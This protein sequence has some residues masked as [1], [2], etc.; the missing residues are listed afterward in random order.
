MT[1]DKNLRR[2][3]RRLKARAAVSEK[4]IEAYLRERVTRAGG[5]CLKYA[6]AIEGGYP[7]RLILL[8]GGRA[9]WCELKSHGCR[10]SE[11]QLR[12]HD[13]LRRL[14]FAVGV[15]DSRSAVDSFI[16]PLLMSLCSGTH[17]PTSAGR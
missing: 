4:S 10:P 12:R 5:L 3:L 2:S 8:P 6:N 15:C 7:D 14:G 13:E 1:S 16:E 17:I 11:L 9:A